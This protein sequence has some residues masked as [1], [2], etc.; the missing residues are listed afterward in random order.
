MRN[1]VIFEGIEILNSLIFK[2]MDARNSMELKIISGNII[3][4]NLSS[5][6]L[7]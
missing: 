2:F 3:G 6:K 1:C 5:S 7:R 4:N